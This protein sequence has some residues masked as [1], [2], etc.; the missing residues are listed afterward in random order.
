MTDSNLSLVPRLDA[1]GAVEGE[2]LQRR[3]V[4]GLERVEKEADVIA[5]VVAG[6]DGPGE[7]VVAPAEDREAGRTL[8]PVAMGELVDLVAAAATEQL[9]E[10]PTSRWKA[11]ATFRSS[12]ITSP[13]PR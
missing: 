10:S 11:S 9:G 2:F 3:A 6:D 8:A 13:Y 5:E 7:P 12:V 1:A 4:V